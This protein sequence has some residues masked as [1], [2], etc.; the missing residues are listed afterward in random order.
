M[1]HQRCITQRDD[2]LTMIDNAT[3]VDWTR[4]N[5]C[6]NV[7][8]RHNVDA[9]DWEWT[10]L[11]YSRRDSVGSM[12]IDPWKSESRKSDFI[13]SVSGTSQKPGIFPGSR[14]KKKKKKNFP[15]FPGPGRAGRKRPI[16]GPS[17]R[18]YF[19]PILGLLFVE[20]LKKG[21]YLGY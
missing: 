10:P 17:K 21:L 13:W 7:V 18:A 19:R 14:K 6:V 2:R 12:I 20:S 8:Q 15:E 16:S 9:Y 11:P 5:K 3:H 4:P 1:I